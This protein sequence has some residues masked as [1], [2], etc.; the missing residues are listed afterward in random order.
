MYVLKVPPLVSQVKPSD[1]WAAGLASFQR[2]TRIDAASSRERLTTR[3]AVCCSYSADGMLPEE[4]VH[5]VFEG[6]SCFLQNV[7]SAVVFDRWTVRSMLES[8]GHLV[9]IRL[10]GNDV[11]HTLVI[12]GVGVPDNRYF[13]VMNPNAKSQAHQAGY[14]N[15]EFSSQNIVAVGYR[16]TSLAK[17]VHQIPP[18]E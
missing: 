11:Y 18:E 9:A 2:V 1:C 13:S 17:H 4:C 8:R 5:P 7:P 14:Q 16:V 12:Y 15:L 3:Y 6:E 10:S